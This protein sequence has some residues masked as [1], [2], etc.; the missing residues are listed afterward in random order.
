MLQHF[1]S[2]KEATFVSRIESRDFSERYDYNVENYVCHQVLRKHSIENAPGMTFWLRSAK[3]LRANLY[4]RDKQ[5]FC[6]K[7]NEY[8]SQNV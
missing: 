8:K 7:T 3:K 4:L 2:L 1:N 6:S 5:T